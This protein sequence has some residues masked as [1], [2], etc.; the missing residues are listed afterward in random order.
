MRPVQPEWIVLSTDE[1]RWFVQDVSM[2][3]RKSG[4]LRPKQEESKNEAGLRSIGSGAIK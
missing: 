3:A 4:S 2:A 1:R